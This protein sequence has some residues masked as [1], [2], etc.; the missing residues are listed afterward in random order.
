[1]NTVSFDGCG[2]AQ[3]FTPRINAAATAMRLNK[4]DLRLAL[5]AVREGQA[6]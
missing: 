2:R 4:A 1:M 6:K 5:I 3:L